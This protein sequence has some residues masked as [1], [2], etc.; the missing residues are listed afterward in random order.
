MHTM[1]GQTALTLVTIFSLGRSVATTLQQFQRLTDR[2]PATR[3]KNCPCKLEVGLTEDAL[4]VFGPLGPRRHSTAGRGGPALR[5]FVV[6]CERGHR[7]AAP[8]DP[9]ENKCYVF[10]FGP[11]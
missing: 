11:G 3:A 8:K 10:G 2:L 9:S 5:P 7:R 1:Q 4:A 6:D